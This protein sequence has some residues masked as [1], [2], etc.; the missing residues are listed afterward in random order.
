MKS[1]QIRSYFWSVF[2]CIRTEYGELVNLR[3]QPEQRKMQTRNN[4]LFGRYSLSASFTYVSDA[5]VSY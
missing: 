4:S 1:V 2:A 5:F 3:I